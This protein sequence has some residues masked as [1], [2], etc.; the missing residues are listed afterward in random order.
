MT[1]VEKNNVLATHA[2]GSTGLTSGNRS[3][4][5]RGCVLEKQVVEVSQD[6]RYTWYRINVPSDC[7]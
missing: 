3:L 1:A 4:E 6:R 2:A 7:S 5:V